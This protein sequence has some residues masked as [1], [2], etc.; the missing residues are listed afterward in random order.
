MKVGD[1]V[2]TLG[3]PEEGVG[4]ILETVLFE[5]STNLINGRRLLVYWPLPGL[6]K[7]PPNSIEWSWEYDLRKYNED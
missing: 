3:Y 1:L 5:D 2:Y 7:Q 6:E 4:L